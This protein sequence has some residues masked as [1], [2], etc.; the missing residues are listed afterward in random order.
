MNQVM[1]FAG[2]HAKRLVALGLVLAFYGF[3]RLPE[4]SESERATL[5][6]NYR[7]T[8]FPLPTIFAQPTVSIRAV[9]PN[10]SRISSWISAVGAAVAISDLDGDGLPNDLCYV[11]PRSNLV[12][13]APVPGTGERYEPF[14]LSTEPLLYDAATMAPMGCLPGDLNEDGRMD[15]LVYYWGRAPVAFLRRGYGAVGSPV[16]LRAD[17]YVPR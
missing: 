6:S 5:A 16:P 17:L 10:L 8:R 13:V 7:F 15:L 9:N 11:D 4:T 12:I 1:A 14:A 3:A 2:R